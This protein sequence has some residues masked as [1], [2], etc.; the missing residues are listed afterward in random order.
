MSLPLFLSRVQNA[1]GPLLGGLSESELGERLDGTTLVLE[2]D[3]DAAEDAANRA[4]FLLAV[5]LG[6]RLYPRL[7]IDAGEALSADAVALARSIN[8][9]C[10]FGPSRGSE[11]VLTWRGGEP[12]AE[13]VTASAQGWAAVIDGEPPLR[14]VPI[15]WPR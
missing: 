6:A 8:P 7:G 10:E 3:H 15:P 11:L 1:A 14:S 13:R 2:I 4:G 5:N 12:A 9:G